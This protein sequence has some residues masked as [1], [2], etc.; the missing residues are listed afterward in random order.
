[1]KKLY[2]LLLLHTAALPLFAQKTKSD[3]REMSRSAINNPAADKKE[4][5]GFTVILHPAPRRTFLYAVY[6]KGK[7][8]HSSMQHPV[9]HT[10]V[11]FATRADAYKSAG[12]AIGEYQKTRSF[13]AAMPPAVAKQL[14][15]LQTAPL[16]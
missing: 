15:L 10:P 11:G 7:L 2:L 8:L 6:E 12:W 1:M 9:H 16:Q 14:N 3:R 13:P 5:D 4:L